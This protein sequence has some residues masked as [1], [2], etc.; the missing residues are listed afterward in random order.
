M[1][2]YKSSN[3]DK[4]VYDL[5][6]VDT[7]SST[8]STL[9]AT[10]SSAIY[11]TNK[12]VA[13]LNSLSSAT[14]DDELD[15]IV[16]AIDE[17]E[18][19]ESYDPDLSNRFRNE[20]LDQN[21]QLGFK[22]MRTAYNLD[23]GVSINPS[24][25][26][27]IDLID[28]DRNIDDR[29]SWNIA[30]YLRYRYKFSKRSTLQMFYRA[31]TS[32]P[33]MTQLQPVV[34]TSNPL[35]IVEGNP[36]LSPTFTNYFN[37]RLNDYSEEKQRSI[38][39]M[40]SAQVSTNSIVNNTTYD[41]TTGG[42]YVT[43]E[44]ANGIW[45]VHLVNM[46]S[47]PLSCNPH[48]QFSHNLFSRYS[49]AASYADDIL[50]RSGTISAT[51]SIGMAY[52]TDVAEIEL[53]PTYTIQ[54]TSYNIDVDN[55][56]TIHTYGASLNGTYYT[57]FGLVLNSDVSYSNSAGY[58]DGFDASQWLWNASLSYQFL[59]N[60]AGTLAIKAYDILQDKKNISRTVT[61]TYI[62]DSQY[63]TLT[64][65]FMASFTYTFKTFGG[66]TPTMQRM[67]RRS[68]PPM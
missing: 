67:E 49:T 13:I 52:R 58:S 45:N 65:Y 34:D 9:S 30:P 57:P 11:S 7:S 10:E 6:E 60:K 68:P 4:L 20:F 63:N 26:R 47:M 28:S 36:D 44:N 2:K 32:E 1:I 12:S 29:W 41:D 24:M 14:T 5:T 61:G 39:L 62:Q 51:E 16:E 21:L 48:W 66:D 59:K 64:R 38:M 53:K 15:A 22:Q 31:R 19:D 56:S 42:Q 33:S 54:A 27:S 17:T 40:L 35:Y 50:S 46:I 55:N 18:W 23:A 43:Y 8:S 25:S 3:A 37:L